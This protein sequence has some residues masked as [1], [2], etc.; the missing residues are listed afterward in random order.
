MKQNVT[1]FFRD[2]RLTQ[3][4]PIPKAV[5][6]MG[7]PSTAVLIYARLLHRGTVS[8]INGY[9]DEAGWVY[10]IYPAEDIARDMG[11][12]RKCIQTNL[13]A[14]EQAGLIIRKRPEGNRANHIYLNIP[15]ESERTPSTSPFALSDVSQWRPSSYA[16]GAASKYN[17]LNNK[18]IYNYEYEEGESL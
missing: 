17:K 16:N 18:R 2:T 6:D 14:L 5:M 15:A 9:T 1:R 8:Q 11:L 4:F 10:V 7:L 3:F 13:K 12:K